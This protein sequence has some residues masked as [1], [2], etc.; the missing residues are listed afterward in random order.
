MQSDDIM[1][2]FVDADGCPVV[3]IAI[4]VA[5]SYGLEIVVVKNYSH[6]LADDYATMSQLMSLQIVQTFISK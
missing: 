1:R 2:I 3:D 5:K 4:K 6:E